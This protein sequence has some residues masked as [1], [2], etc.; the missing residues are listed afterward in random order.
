MGDWVGAGTHSFGFPEP[1]QKQKDALGS[2]LH[3]ISASLLSY[4][5]RS[6]SDSQVKPVGRLDSVGDSV[7][8]DS[9]GAVGLGDG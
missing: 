1:I 9:V 3:N 7:V 8:G 6:F 4:L 2:A 5:V